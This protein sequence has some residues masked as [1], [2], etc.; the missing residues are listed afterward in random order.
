MCYHNAA[1]LGKEI[2]YKDTLDCIFK[3]ALIK[4]AIKL[5]TKLPVDKRRDFLTYLTEAYSSH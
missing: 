4:S 1:M 2:L 3:K 5:I